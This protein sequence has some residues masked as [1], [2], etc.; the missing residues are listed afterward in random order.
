MK[1]A[2]IKAFGALMCDLWKCS[3]EAERVLTTA[4]LKSQ[5]QL[6]ASR[7]MDHQQQDAQEFLRFLLEGLH[8]DV[9]RVTSRPKLI[10][11][12]IDDS[13]SVSQKSMKAWERF[14]RLE[15][16]KFVDLFVGQL[17]STL[18]CT[19]CGHASVTF[20]QFWN[21]SLPI[22][23]KTGQV[24]L[25]ACFELFTKEEVLDGDEK[26]TCSKCQKLQKCTKGFSIQK[27]PLILVVHWKRFSSQE[28]FRGK[29]DTAVDFSGNRLD[30]SPYSAGRAP[31][32]YN[33]YGVVNHS[34]TLISG[35]YTACCRHPYTDEWYEYN[36]SSVH[37]VTRDNVNSGEGY[38]FFFELA[39]SSHG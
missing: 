25:Q 32:R 8:E 38:V 18:R 36:D 4:P 9:N 11:T 1:G 29:L 35:H 28:M 15:N 13:I 31:C 26:P 14:L 22:P 3:D 34:G 12:D 27:F 21:L 5:I 39:G 24:R 10:M 37:P 23:S 7:F 16:S 6:F 17:K 20:D 2:M 33:L 30:L 19:V